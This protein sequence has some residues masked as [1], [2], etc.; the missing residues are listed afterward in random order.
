MTPRLPNST[1]WTDIPAELAEKIRE[2]FAQQFREDSETGEFIVE[3]RIYEKEILM[4]V[5]YLPKGRLRQL[6]LEAS[7]EYSPEILAKK[8]QTTMDPIYLA[9]DAIGSIMDEILQSIRGA[10]DVL[11]SEDLD[12]PRDW[13]AVELDGEDVFLKFTTVNSKLE[14]EADRLLGDYKDE[15]VHDEILGLEDETDKG[16]H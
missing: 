7:I 13:T 5:G 16:L 8:Q 6:N 4:R 9:V 11:E 14:A 10:E 2:V 15:L 3:G 1:K 12:L